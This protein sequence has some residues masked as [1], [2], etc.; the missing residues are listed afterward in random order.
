MTTES[1][2]ARLRVRLLC[3]GAAAL[4]CACGPGGPKRETDDGSGGDSGPSTGIS[5]LAGDA[6]TGGSAE[7]KGS[8][9]RFNTPRGIAIDANGNLYVADQLNY[10]IRKIVP[11]G[12]VSTFAGKR[13]ASG[14]K[15]G[16]GSNAL[17]SQP[18]AI[19]IDGSGNLFVTDGLA[20]RKVTPE[21][22]V[23]TVTTLASGDF[24]G[25][26][27]RFPGGIATDG[28]GNL[29]VTTGNDTRRIQIANP[30]SW[31]RL[32]NIAVDIPPGATDPITRGVAVDA[33][34]IAY[35]ADLRRGISRATSGASNLAQ[36]AA[37]S[38]QAGKADGNASQ[39][40]F[41][42]VVGL[43]ID[44]NGDLF[45]ADAVNNTIR[46]ITTNAM[47]TTAAGTAGA[48]TL[49]TGKL[50][51]SFAALRGITVAPDGTLY[52]TSG[53]AVVKIVL[54]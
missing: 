22:D 23:S 43:C 29:I 3:A 27:R 53:N 41:Q 19:T 51:G 24:G 47:V 1:V 26:N 54:P 45:A 34:D 32:E 6:V 38:G 7:G 17:F 2:S 44:K 20:I 36:F 14:T 8:S 16:K 12:T 31:T 33:D 35:V 46:K 25:D 9:A 39:A 52:A 28:A 4:L 37:T 21:G 42:Q 11:D 48:T 5:V 49:R 40:T 50:P 15:D 10:A 30:R 13:G 18:T